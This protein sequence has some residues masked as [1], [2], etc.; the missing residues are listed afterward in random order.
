[1][2]KLFV[3]GLV[4]MFVFMAFFACNDIAEIDD[5][6]PYLVLSNGNTV[7]LT[8]QRI[9][10]DDLYDIM[11]YPY[12]NMVN[13]LSSRIEL[14]QYCNDRKNKLEQ[15]YFDEFGWSMEVDNIL[16]KFE[17]YSDD[18][19]KNNF[20]IIVGL[21]EGSGSIG[22]KVEKIDK[23]GNIF[24]KRLLPE[25][26]TCDMAGWSIIIEINND[27]KLEQYQVKI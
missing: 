19:F 10:T 11:E 23:N 8:V 1:M 14:E 18:Y 13:V 22:H 7:E 4:L 12:S 27:Y 2:K 17:K 25:E 15:Y 3:F 6:N 9:R 26:G 20:L 24:I 16:G 21:V 5:V